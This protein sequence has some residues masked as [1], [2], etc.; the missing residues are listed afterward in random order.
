MT[1]NGRGFGFVTFQ[2][3][4]GAQSISILYYYE[5]NAAGSALF[6]CVCVLV[7]CGRIAY[8]VTVVWLVP[9]VAER[10]VAQKH[11]IR[12][13]TVG[14][15]RAGVGLSLSTF[16]LRSSSPCISAAAGGGNSQQ[17]YVHVQKQIQRQGFRRGGRQFCVQST[18]QGFRQSRR[19]QDVHS[20]Q[21][22]ADKTLRG[23]FQGRFS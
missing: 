1:G 7:C 11:E 17:E 12:G 10:V 3:K 20:R 15:C 14:V 16:A 2:D 18:A 23:D 22:I 21:G 4:K 6:P 8:V 9:P 13:R 5:H 19:K